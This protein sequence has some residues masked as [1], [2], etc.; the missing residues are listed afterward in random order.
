MKY[1]EVTIKTTHE[2]ADIIADAL[3][4]VGCGGVSIRDKFDILELYQSD[5]IW[6]YIDESL[7]QNSD[8]TVYVKGIIGEESKAETLESLCAAVERIRENS[9]FP[10]GSL[11]T[12]VAVLD[13]EDWKNEWKKYYKP[14]V[15]TSVTVVPDW[16][17][18]SAKKGEKLL[19]INPGMA[20]G[21]G[22]H[23]TTN[24]CLT[25]LGG[26]DAHGKEIIDVGTGS[27]ILGIA[28]VLC[29]ARSAYMCDIDTA[30]ITS[31]K[32]NARLNS[33]EE[34]CIIEAA[35]LLT[36]T[37]VKADILFA[38]ITADI[39]IRLSK[40]LVNYIN[41][42]GKVILSGIIHAR[43]NDVRSAYEAVGLTCIKQVTLGEWNA[44]LF[45]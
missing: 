9:P 30:A 36:K 15:T 35:D 28:A 42:N 25:L 32:E 11:E 20:F 33:V 5:V 39:L 14:I 34:S 18:Y 38:N 24:M 27:G 31:A 16:I 21:T 22:E 4:S 44:L 43:L 26:L 40:N 19:Y 7:T 6:D 23:E 10:V 45:G 1:F 12:T 2:C 3:F 37:D 17:K 29:G 8:E 13:D 41:P